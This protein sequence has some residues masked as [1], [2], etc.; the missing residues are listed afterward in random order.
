MK[1]TGEEFHRLD[2]TAYILIELFSYS[3]T[4]AVYL[5]DCSIC[6]FS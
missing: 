6:A 5:T 2:C 3:A 4:E 1:K